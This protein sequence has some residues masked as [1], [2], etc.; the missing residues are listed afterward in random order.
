MRVRTLEFIENWE[1]DGNY[2][3]ARNGF[4]S[5]VISR[6]Q[7]SWGWWLSLGSAHAAGEEATAEAAIEAAK[8]RYVEL[9]MSLLEVEPAPADAPQINFQEIMAANEQR[10]AMRRAANPGPWTVSPHMHDNWGCVRDGNG[11]PVADTC[12]SAQYTE[13]EADECRTRRTADGRIPAP[14]KVEANAQFVAYAA[15]DNATEVIDELLQYIDW[16]HWTHGTGRSAAPTAPVEES[17]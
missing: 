7:G 4:A 8:R 16:L 2:W 17:A 13:A 10:K 11:K 12:M 9:V 15:N 3:H 5:G 6:L 1:V 14:V